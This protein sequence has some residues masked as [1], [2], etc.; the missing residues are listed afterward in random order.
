MTVQTL[1]TQRTLIN[2]QWCTHAGE[3]IPVLSP[4]NGS[5][6]AS[7]PR[8]G[9]VEIEAAVSGAHTAL[10]PWSA[11]APAERAA[12]LRR[13]AD[14]IERDADKLAQIIS[15]DVGTPMR[16]SRA[17][18][19]GL[20]VRVLRSIADHA[21]SRPFEERIAHSLVLSVPVGIVAAIT[22]WNYP[23]HQSIAKIAAALAAGC[24]VVHKPSE[25][26]PLGPLLMAEL[27]DE[28]GLPAGVYNQVSGLGSEVGDMLVRHP[29]VD[30]VSFTGSTDIG[31]SI[32]RIAAESFKRVSLELGGK[33]ASLV[34]PGA[35]LAAAVKASVNNAF[36]NSGQ[37]CTAWSR[38]L[39]HES[40]YALAVQLL[41]G[42]AEEMEPRLGPL[43][44]LEQWKRVQ[45]HVSDAVEGGGRV[46]QG[47]LGAPEG[48]TEGYF[49]RATIIGD[50]APES[51]IAQQEVFGPVITVLPY[52]TIDEAIS[53]ANNTA[54]GLAAG[55]WGAT[56]DEA[57]TVARR[58][59]SGQVDINGAAFNPEAPFGGFK[60]SGIGRE[61][62]RYG[63]EEFLEPIAI[64][65]PE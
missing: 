28:A 36:L 25:V 15:E 32:G 64:Q 49:A 44:S 57:V 63:V 34:L 41:A 43:A 16:V 56:E 31:R 10:E 3:M 39:V 62:G 20:P 59:R 23:L 7:V 42:R 6:I 52:A 60:S 33:S 18:Q 61:F 21:E 58:I 22:P 65:L 40:D 30:A 19:V 9:A 53:I 54:Y 2:G 4:L 1:N 26:A 8:Q 47:G 12:F 45:E 11:T 27:I 29:L 14:L 37:T 24:T 55:V 5:E 48:R 51:G 35:D 46:Y 13:L 50:V 38:F 17:V